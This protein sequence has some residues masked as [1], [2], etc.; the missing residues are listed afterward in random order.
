MQ[1]AGVSGSGEVQAHPRAG[2]EGAGT[3]DALSTRIRQA[4]DGEAEPSSPTR[5]ATPA[6]GK[7]LRRHVSAASRPNPIDA[8]ARE[9]SVLD[10]V[11]EERGSQSPCRPPADKPR[12]GWVTGRLAPRI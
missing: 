1:V 12:V 2:S 5:K 8:P 11:D 4:G 3:T 10:P 7:M 6:R 9:T